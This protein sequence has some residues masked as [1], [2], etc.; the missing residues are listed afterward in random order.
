[1]C[2]VNELSVRY[3]LTGGHD[4]FNPTG[5]AWNELSASHDW[6]CCVRADE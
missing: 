5:D 3:E 2:T 1:V 4:L 6:L